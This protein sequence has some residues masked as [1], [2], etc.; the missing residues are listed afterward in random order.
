[1]GRWASA[2]A[3]EPGPALLCS[4]ET[5]VVLGNVSI[6]QKNGARPGQ[7]QGP[8]CSDPA[9]QAQP[10]HQ[11]VVEEHGR[12]RHQDVGEAHVEDDGGPCDEDKAGPRVLG[13]APP[14]ASPALSGARE[15]GV[16]RGRAGSQ[17]SPGLRATRGRTW[18]FVVQV[19][20][21]GDEAV[22]GQQEAHA[23]QQHGEVDGVVTVL[24]HW[25]LCR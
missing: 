11:R 6:L 8:T 24:G 2:A 17:L 10:L 25:L 15:G 14:P 7:W 5:H 20:H 4:M 22:V 18:E 16:P 23:G 13:T 1:M 9:V 12:Q 19:V 3:E 21:V